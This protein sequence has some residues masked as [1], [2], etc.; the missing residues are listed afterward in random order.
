[1]QAAEGGPGERA[2]GAGQGPQGYRRKQGQQ[3]TQKRRKNS[4]SHTLTNINVLFIAIIQID[5]YTSYSQCC[6]SVLKRKYYFL[7]KKNSFYL[8]LN[9]FFFF[10]YWFT[11]QRNKNILGESLVSLFCKSVLLD[12]N[13]DPGSQKRI[14]TTDY[15][16]EINVCC[17]Y[18]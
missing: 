15:P 11:K 7:K 1:M 18:E 16:S 14:I 10:F 4:T 13:P 2:V 9:R 12:P 8:N 5:Q 6:K 17:I 3:H